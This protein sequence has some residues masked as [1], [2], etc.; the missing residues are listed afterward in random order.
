MARKKAES[1]GLVRFGW[2]M[3]EQHDECMVTNNK[4]ECECDCENH[5]VNYKVLPG[6]SPM[7][8][9]ISDRYYAKGRK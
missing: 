6:M 3:T 9:E 1:D 7:L 4:L 8:Q 2:C 5:G